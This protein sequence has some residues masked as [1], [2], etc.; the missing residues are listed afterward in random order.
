MLAAVIAPRR[1][2]PPAGGPR[3]LRLHGADH[4]AA[5]VPQR[6]RSRCSSAS[7]SPSPSRRRCGRSTPGC[8]TRRPRRRPG[9]RC[10]SSACSTRSARSASCGSASRCSRTR[11]RTFAPY[12]L[13]LAVVGIIYGALLAIGQRDLKRLVAYTSV[14]HFGFITLGVFAFTSQGGSGATLYMVNH[15]F[16][17]GALFLLVGFLATRRGSRLIDDFGGC[18]PRSRRGW[19]AMFLAGR[20]VRAVA[21]RPVHVRQRVPRA[22]RARSP[23]TAGSPSW[24]RSASSSPRSTCCSCS[25]ARSTARCATGVEGMA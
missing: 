21:A 2:S 19:P 8:R 4:A 12:V 17:T 15:G 9:W 13:A 11:P 10:C 16:S 5:H 23:S 3:D 6:S 22:G 24:R 14:S 18:Q 7:S 20:P 1:S 25:S